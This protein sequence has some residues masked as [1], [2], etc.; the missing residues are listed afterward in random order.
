[1]GPAHKRNIFAVQ[2][3]P[4]STRMTR[5]EAMNVEENLRNMIPDNNIDQDVEVENEAL[6]GRTSGKGNHKSKRVP[7]RSTSAADVFHTRRVRPLFRHDP[8]Y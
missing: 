4:V 5:E 3:T 8:S 6:S 7:T 1:M 2:D